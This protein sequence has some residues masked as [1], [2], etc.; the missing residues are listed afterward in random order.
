MAVKEDLSKTA[1]SFKKVV[2]PVVSEWV[3]GDLVS[4]EESMDPRMANR[5]DRDSGIDVWNFKGGGGT[6][7]VASRIQWGGSVL[8]KNN[9]PQGTFT[10]RYARSSG[11][12][13]EYQKRKKEIF[14]P[15]PISPF[16]TVQA[17]LTEPV[18]DPICIAMVETEKLIRFIMDEM[19]GKEES[20][21]NPGYGINRS[22]DSPDRWADFYWVKWWHL[23]VHTTVGVRTW[24]SSKPYDEEA[25]ASLT[26]TSLDEFNGSDNQ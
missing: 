4:N 12:E 15:A 20:L 16:Y 26:N 21:S 3:S 6:V 8:D 17:Y 11:A 9:Q 2:A 18:G 7:G 22:N 13:T 1:K 25:I 14:S 5:F 19:E 23:D 24:P 10:V